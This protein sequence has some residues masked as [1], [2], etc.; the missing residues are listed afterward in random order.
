M[1]S[2]FLLQTFSVKP[3]QFTNLLMFIFFYRRKINYSHKLQDII[4]YVDS[5]KT[6]RQ[7]TRFDCHGTALYG[8]LEEAFFSYIV[9]RNGNQMRY[10]GGG[11]HDGRGSLKAVV[12]F[13]A[14]IRGSLLVNSRGGA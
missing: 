1:Y 13:Y 9:D 6:C 7:F 14:L 2:D 10:I 3:Y 11:P 5:S 4:E 12:L 8:V